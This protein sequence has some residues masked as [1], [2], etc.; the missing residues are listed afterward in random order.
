MSLLD[1]SRTLM[2]LSQELQIPDLESLPI[3]GLSGKL[4]AGKDLAATL[5]KLCMTPNTSSV[6][7]RQKSFATRLKETV[8]AMLHLSSAG[9]LNTEEGKNAVYPTWN[10][11]TGGQ[12]LQQIG[13]L[14]REQYGADVWINC[15]MDEFIPQHDHWIITDVRHKTEADKIRAM[16]GIVIRLNGDPG[17]VRARSTRNLT[18][19]SETD[20]DDYAHFDAVIDN[21]VP[22]V[23]ILARALHAELVRIIK[24]KKDEKNKE[25]TM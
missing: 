11:Q 20:L 24:D 12:L 21:S 6:M 16:G 4:G 8:A 22:D 7:W 25:E 9:V 19:I 17:G 14:M 5:I 2:F 18:H 15:M 23:T 3:I 10:N 1:T 13:A